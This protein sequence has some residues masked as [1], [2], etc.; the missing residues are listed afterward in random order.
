VIHYLPSHCIVNFE[1]NS[2]VIR[3]LVKKWI[4]F[5]FKIICCSVTFN[6]LLVFVPNANTLCIC[7]YNI[8]TLV[9]VRYVFCCDI[10]AGTMICL[11]CWNVQLG[12]WQWIVHEML[13]SGSSTCSVLFRS[14]ISLIILQ[15]HLMWRSVV[16]VGERSSWN[17]CRP[18]TCIAVMNLGSVLSN[19]SASEVLF[20]LM[21]VCYCQSSVGGL[22]P[23]WYG[24]SGNALYSLF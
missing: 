9:H 4:Q 10:C 23:C 16:S 7:V 8:K 14:E 22:V 24:Y 17:F 15:Q 12:C 20:T 19:Y 5:E 3:L 18:D 11:C 2:V 13:N 21:W 6:F 1:W